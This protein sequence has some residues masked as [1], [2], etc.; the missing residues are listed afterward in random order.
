MGDFK[1]LQRRW[2]A[3]L[4]SEGFTDV[5]TLLNN[6]ELADTLKQPA[7]HKRNKYQHP[8]VFEEVHNFYRLAAWF[9]HEYNF[10]DEIDKRAWELFSEGMTYRDI[11]E[12]I[13]AEFVADTKQQRAHSVR[14]PML[15]ARKNFSSA[16]VFKRIQILIKGPFQD[17]R[18]MIF[19]NAC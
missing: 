4:K 2:Y 9:Y 5:E 19:F 10:K 3:I 8:Y 18:K 12:V 16:F 13:S 6:G 11:A 7:V 15:S 14:L 1:K 17:Y